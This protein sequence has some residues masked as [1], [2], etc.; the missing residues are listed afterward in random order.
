[1]PA[2]CGVEQA[3]FT[4]A[5]CCEACSDT[6][7]GMPRSQECDAPAGS[8]ADLRLPSPATLEKA[9]TLPSTPSIE[10]AEDTCYAER[11]ASKWLATAVHGP[12]NLQPTAHAA[13]KTARSTSDSSAVAAL[14]HKSA[15]ALTAAAEAASTSA[16]TAIS[17]ASARHEHDISGCI[18]DPASCEVCP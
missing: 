11:P 18:R 14:L 10:S 17:M 13:E 1:M 16:N 6:A 15:A 8:G 3:G 4:G 9:S 12:P 7:K 2:C 5:A